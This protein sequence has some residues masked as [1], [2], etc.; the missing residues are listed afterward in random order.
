MRK[1]P[2]FSTIQSGERQRP[3]MMQLALASGALAQPHLLKGKS[4]SDEFWNKDDGQSAI[5]SME[6]IVL[7]VQRYQ[8]HPYKRMGKRG[9][10]VWEDG[11]ASVTW[12]ASAKKT[13]KRRTIFMIPSMINGAEI[14]DILPEK[15]SLISWL[16]K[17]GFDVFLFEWGEMREDAELTNLDDA[18]GRKLARAVEWVRAEVDGNLVGLGYCMGGVFLAAVEIL[19][20]DIFDKLVFVATP[21]DFNAGAKGN[22]AEALTSWAKDG[23]RQVVAQDYMPNEWLQM[24]F[25]GVNPTQMARKLSALA[26]MRQGSFDETLFV[27]VEDWVNGGCDIPSGIIRQAVKDWY[28]DNKTVTGTWCIHRQKI[29]ARQIHKPSLVIIPS[30]D[31]IVPPASARALARQIKGADKLVADCGHI[32]MM[33][34]AKAEKEVWK[35]LRDWVIKAR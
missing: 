17:Q 31:K 2:Q 23:L 22:F 20:P 1:T 25:A 18:I 32:S 9:S 10:V 28:I 34:G 29:D 24:I 8:L 27:A 13:K 11:Q 5:A 4:F 33:V 21:W 26:D 3:V 16:T 19:H 12:F 7:G 14:L 35:P 6:K 15:R 30:K